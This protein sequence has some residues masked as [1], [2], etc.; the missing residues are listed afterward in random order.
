[1]SVE[2]GGIAPPS[3]DF[4]P[5]TSTSLVLRIISLMVAPVNVVH[6]QLADQVYG[7]TYQRPQGS[8]LSLMT[9]NAERTGTSQ[10]R[11]LATF[12]LTTSL[13]CLMQQRRQIDYR[14]H[15]LVSES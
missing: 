7:P 1:M 12:G 13:Y 8:I 15:L 4:D 11:R 9:P 5:R 14:L 10:R 2:A 6:H 3:N